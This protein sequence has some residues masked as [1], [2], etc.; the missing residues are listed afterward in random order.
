MTKSPVSLL[1]ATIVKAKIHPQ[2][3]TG[4]HISSTWIELE[5]DPRRGEGVDP[6]KVLGI[7]P[8]KTEQ[9]KIEGVPYKNA[10]VLFTMSES[11]N[12]VKEVTLTFQE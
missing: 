12:S 5:E 11:Y 8:P 7:S 2:T 9:E 3:G 4:I 6:Y 1:D 10:K